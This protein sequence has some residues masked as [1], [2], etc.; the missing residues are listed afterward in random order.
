MALICLCIWAFG[1]GRL[2]VGFSDYLSFVLVAPLSPPPPPPPPFS[3]SSFCFISFSAP[4][5][6][7]LFFDTGYF[8]EQGFIYPP[9]PLT[10]TPPRPTHPVTFSFYFVSC[11][12][13]GLVLVVRYWLCFLTRRNVPVFDTGYF[14]EQ[15]IYGPPPPCNIL[16]YFVSCTLVGLVLVV[17]YWSCFLT[18]RSVPVFDT[19]LLRRDLLPPTPKISTP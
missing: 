15:G 12:L 5:E 3:F 7:Y 19:V 16:F 8:V 1:P 14:V 18:K 11:T 10:P 17:W 6:T 2:L 4:S 13:V 9:P